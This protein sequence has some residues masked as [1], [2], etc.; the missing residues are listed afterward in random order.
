MEFGLSTYLY[1]NERLSPHILDRIR[2]AGIGKIEI[3]AARQHFDYYDPNHVGDIAR[4][5]ADHGLTLHSL[6]APVHGGPDMDATKRLVISVAHLERRLR[7][8]SMEEIKRAIDI[9]ERLPFRYLVLHLGLSDEAYDTRKLDAAFTSIEHLNLYAKGGGAQILLENIPNELSTPE[10]LVEFI[11]YTHLE[12]LEVCFDTGHAHLGEGVQASFQAL[13][14]F[15]VST[16]VHDNLR[17]KDDHLL[18]FEGSIDWEQ[19]VRDLNRVSAQLPLIFELRQP[20]SAGDCLSRV[21]QVI[22]RMQAMV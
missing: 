10:R 11:Q 8:D 4:W 13:K 17:E 2:N 19:T 1:V 7:I 16:H 21:Q 12:G 22:Q 5:F 18:P 14:R 15:V 6:H 20:A 3:F 9:S